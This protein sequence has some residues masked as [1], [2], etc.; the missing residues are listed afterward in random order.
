[1]LEHLHHPVRELEK[2]KKI[3]HPDGILYIQVPYELFHW[4]EIME[5]ILKG[6]NPGS[7]TP[8]ALPAHLYFFSP[9]TLRQFLIKCGYKI[10]YRASGNYGE[11]RSKIDPPDSGSG[12][13][14]SRYLKKIYYEWGIQRL[15]YFIA[16]KIKQGNGIIYIATP[17]R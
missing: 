1:M 10:L 15:F 9:R 8:D 2:I 6:M 11:I 4:E 5:A 17:D 16:K 12:S 7:I 14:S 3:L 13:L